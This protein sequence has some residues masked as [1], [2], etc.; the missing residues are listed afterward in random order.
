MRAIAEQTG[1]AA[2]HNRNDIATAI[3]EALDDGRVSYTLGFYR[4][5]GGR[6]SEIRHLEVRV[7]QP[8][9][10]LRY[11]TSYQTEAP[12]PVNTMA[13]LARALYGP[14]EAVDVPLKATA[15]R[16]QDRL[17]VHVVADLVSLELAQNND[18][19]TGKI[20]I[21]ARF[22]AAD[23]KPAGAVVSQ[24]LNLNLRPATYDVALRQGIAYHNV[25]KVPPKAVELRL[26]FANPAA[27]KTGTLTI[28]LSEVSKSEAKSP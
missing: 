6:A 26:L 15:T 17:D 24:T 18:H 27:R 5:A 8:G 3:G 14:L 10:A 19:R 25:L 9:I 16:L 20:E 11:R 4:S 21:V 7:R 12:L 2:F 23:G 1:G 13:D 28:P 22:L